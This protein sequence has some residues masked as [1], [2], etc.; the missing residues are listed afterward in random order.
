MEKVLNSWKK[1]DENS[2]K[3]SEE[4]EE[5]DLLYNYE[6]LMINIK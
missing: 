2:W 5:F 4:D 3:K 6:L 1:S